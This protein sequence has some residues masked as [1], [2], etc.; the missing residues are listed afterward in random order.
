[1]DY[2]LHTENIHVVGSLQ[3][4]TAVVFRREK[5]E[6]TTMISKRVFRLFSVGRH[7]LEGPDGDSQNRR[8]VLCFVFRYL[9]TPK[10]SPIYSSQEL[11]QALSYQPLTGNH[12]DNKQYNN[13]SEDE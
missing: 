11:L 4:A 9:E 6:I 8:N 12:A 5:E 2:R 1:M 7:E 10:L 3:L 13:D